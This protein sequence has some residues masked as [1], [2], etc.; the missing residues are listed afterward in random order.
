MKLILTATIKK[1]AL[2]KDDSHYTWYTYSSDRA[3]NF[4][5]TNG[6]R[7]SRLTKGSKFGLRPSSNGKHIRMITEEHGTNIVFTITDSQA[8]SLKKKSKEKK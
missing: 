8:E 7:S 1:E 2:I 4:T 3:M 5:T 6:K